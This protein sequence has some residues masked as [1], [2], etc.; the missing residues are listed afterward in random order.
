MLKKGVKWDWTND[1]ERD[2]QKIKRFLISDLFLAHF[3]PKQEIV[4]AL[5]TSGYGIDVVILH[6]FEDGTTKPVAHASTLLLA[7][8]RKKGLR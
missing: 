2:F 5:D 7:K 8:L 3:N 1:C 6:R 4:V